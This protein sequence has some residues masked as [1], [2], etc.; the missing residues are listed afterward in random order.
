MGC[1]DT[2]EDQDRHDQHQEEAEP[3]GHG[4]VATFQRKADVTCRG[5]KGEE[6]NVEVQ[7]AG[8]DDPKIFNNPEQ[9]TKI[10]EKEEEELATEELTRR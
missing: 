7:Y 10:T 3:E 5:Y 1:Y 9:D 8:Q 2:R 4:D 6:V